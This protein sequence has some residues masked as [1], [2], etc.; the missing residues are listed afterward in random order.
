MAHI[1]PIREYIGSFVANI[2][3]LYEIRA[4]LVRKYKI[5]PVDT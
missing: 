4:K 1:S 3:K 5:G 2:N